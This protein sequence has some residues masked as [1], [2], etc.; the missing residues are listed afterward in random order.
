MTAEDLAVAFEDAMRINGIKFSEAVVALKRR[1]M[2]N[3]LERCC[4]NQCWAAIELGWHR[5]TFSYNA[6]LVGIDLKK[7]KREHTLKIRPKSIGR[8]AQQ[9]KGRSA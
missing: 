5:N 7:Y 6:K 9:L 1:V 4:N 8:I 2:L 3:T